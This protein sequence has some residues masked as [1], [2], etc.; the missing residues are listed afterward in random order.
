MGK[1][2]RRYW[3][4]VLSSSEISEP[5]GPQVRVKILGEPLLAFRDTEGR[6]ALIDEHCA[7]RGAS[8]FFGRNEESG[9]RCSY[10]G[11]KFDINGQCV[12]LPSVPALAPKMS[13]K[14]Y[15]C[16]ERGG[17]VWAYM[18]PK[19]KQ[20]APPELEWCGLPESHRFVSKRLQECSWLQAMEGGIDTTHASWVHRYELDKD[21]MHREA[22]ANKYIKA[23][24]NAVFDV[25]DMPHGLSIYGRRNGEADSYYW[26][27]TQY[28]FPWY[29]LIPPFG[30]H[31]LGGHVWV[32]IDD[33]HCWAWSINFYPDKPLAP[34]ER[35]DLEEGMGIHVKYV[36]GTFRPTANKD[37]DYL[38]DRV[39][40]REKRSFSG[41]EGFSVQDASLQESMGPIQDHSKEHLVATDKPISMARR[42]LFNAALSLS[43][44]IE[45]PALDASVQRVR[46]ASV[47][48]DKNASVTEWA[49]EALYDELGQ[50][51]FSL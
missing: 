41:V 26:R 47:L 40:Q 23:D 31:P 33:E 32:P 20:P 38:I 49:N 13:I 43:Q 5:D 6:P 4:P 14:A 19:D 44:G 50:P 22:K 3:V 7:H 36:P 48:L 37:N 24:R 10:H 35:R 45:P 9:I 27:I 30:P 16:I 51:V 12:E 18:G 8:L 17:L 46:A 34:Q 21:P 1:L 29:T 15:P 2:M 39:A 11:W 28:I 25:D 42:M